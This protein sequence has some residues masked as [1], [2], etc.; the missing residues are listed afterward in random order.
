M[1]CP[2]SKQ[3]VFQGLVPAVLAAGEF[4]VRN[5]K[6][7]SMTK[8]LMIS[9]IGLSLF[10]ICPRMAGMVNVIAKH[11]QVSL[12]YVALLGSI[13][14]IP[15]I[16]AIVLIFANFGLWG[17]LAFCIITD[18]GA[19]FMM[20]EINIGAGI[21]TFIIAIFVLIGV[22]VAPYVTNIFMKL[23]IFNG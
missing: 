18:L 21:E 6:G 1:L 2:A 12:I 3:V 20:K 22:K 13:L 11:S 19:A 4:G 15:L 14:A 8:E 5:T 7:E 16:V 23:Q 9:S 17:A 10:I